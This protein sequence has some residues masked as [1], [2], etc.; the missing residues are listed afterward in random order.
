MPRTFGPDRPAH[1]SASYPALVFAVI[2]V[3]IFLLHLPLLQ[4]PYF[5]DEAGYYVPAA[6]DLLLT[7]SLIPH[8]TVSNAHPPLVMA[9][10]ALW[11]KVVGF[12]PPVTRTAMLVLA[13][14]SLLGVFRLAERVAN[15]TVAIASTLCTALYPVF[16]AQSSLAQVDLAAAG[17]TFWG[18][19]AYVE[20]ENAAT[21]LWFAL[22]ALA[23]ETAILA[24]I[25]LF[26]W[27]IVGIF[28]RNGPF[29]KL[30]LDGCSPQTN[31]A[32]ARRIASLLI[33]TL[34][35]GLWYVYHY[36]R[37]AY[38]FGN[39]EFFRYNVAATLSAARF[40]LAL[41][42]RLWQVVGYLHLWVLTVPVL[43]AM[44]LLPP[45]RDAA[46]ERARISLPV[47]M[48][49]YVVVLTY[50][51]AM[52]LIGGAVLA[53]YMLPAVPLV[54]ILSVSTL[55][56]RLRYWPAAVVFV[57]LAF[58]AAWFWNPHYGFSPEDNL[59]YRDYIVLH[60][61]GER[62][63]EA[64]YPMARVLTAWPASDE[65]ARPWLGYITRPMRVVRIEN[66]SLDE[67][68]SAADFRSNYEVALIFSTKYEPGPSPWDRWKRW[69]ELK[70]RYF[71][72][73][74]D[75]PPAAAAQLL[76]GNVV[77][78]EQRQGQWI[79]VIAVEKNEIQNAEVRMQK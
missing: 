27:E 68:L 72:F 17:L 8:S 66:F 70:S 14:F 30:W 1:W 9:W 51:V 58:V 49:F 71:G 55:W 18:L 31:H 53:R 47:Q 21:V 69:T 75:L 16:F 38:V 11:W 34:P 36:A 62:F 4:L 43:L 23:K 44:F 29:G 19:A 33:P 57:A 63:L 65:I 73:H 41:I 50:V 25:A 42:M 12:A 52:A 37:T 7:G 39:P 26:A 28:A 67:M 10:L 79:A 64:R 24:P 77:F 15:R 78:S 76:G 32:H 45:Q 74:R 35:L 6:R 5:W 40:F 60:Q 59:A 56:R 54:I 2:F 3:F 13:A 46:S 61:D 20:G 48:L 22:A